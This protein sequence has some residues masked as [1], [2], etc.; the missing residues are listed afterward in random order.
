MKWK[1]KW[2]AR[3]QA[4]W[5][6]K[7]RIKWPIVTRADFKRYG[8]A[9]LKQ[10]ES[11]YPLIVYGILCL[12]VTAK[13]HAGVIRKVEVTADKPTVVHVCRGRSTAIQFWTKPEK[14]VLGSPGKV[15]VEFLGKDVTVSPLAS[16]PGNL[17][18]YSRGSRFVILFKNAS[19]S[20][21]DDVVE[22]SP[23]KAKY[24]RP[25]RL[26]R[27]SYQTVI[28]ELRNHESGDSF[29]IA[30]LLKNE[31]KEVEINDGLEW[32]GRRKLSCAGCVVRGMTPKTQ[33]A[34]ILCAN[35]I[36]ALTCKLSDGNSFTLSRRRE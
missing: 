36:A 22:L 21:Y 27:D 14:L 7:W 28:L 31:G 11:V 35:P 17:L 19:E 2:P 33:S 30:A 18:V 6:D 32:I 1:L 26:E 20:A 10:F 15:Q 8:K 3:W 4:K 29:E 13:V 5:P 34:T 16:D 9:L 25:V 23:G 12:L 24:V